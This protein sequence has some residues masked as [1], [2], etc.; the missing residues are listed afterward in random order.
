MIDREILIGKT[1]SEI[2]TAQPRWVADW[3]VVNEPENSATIPETLDGTRHNENIDQWLRPRIRFIFNFKN[4]N[5]YAE[6]EKILVLGTFICNYYQPVIKKRFTGCF[7]LN[8][9]QVQLFLMIRDKFEGVVNYQIEAQSKFTYDT[10]EQL[11]S[12]AEFDTR[13]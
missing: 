5:D 2:S 10:W 12:L 8:S 1:R 3:Q 4:E 7:Q 11:E 9:R 6:A 13:F